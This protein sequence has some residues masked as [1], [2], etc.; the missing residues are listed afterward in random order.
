MMAKRKQWNT[1]TYDS[2]DRVTKV[3]APDNISVTERFYNEST[4]PS[5]ATQGAP[6]AQC[7]SGPVGPRA[8]GRFDAQDRLVEIVEPDPLGNG[9]VAGNGLLTLYG[10]D[11]LGNLISVNQGGQTRA[12]RYDSFSRMSL[13]N[14]PNAMR[15]SMTTGIG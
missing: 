12:F 10:Y 3:T 14:W 7:A 1:I 13:R 15:H 11:T 9:S 4:Y 6:G 2:L 8:M 5:A